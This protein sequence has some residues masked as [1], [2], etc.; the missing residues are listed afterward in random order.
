[1]WKD[2][3]ALKITG[4]HEVKSK[5]RTPN[6]IS[7]LFPE[8]DAGFLIQEVSS[9]GIPHMVCRLKRGQVNKINEWVKSGQDNEGVM[10][11]MAKWWDLC[12][13]S[14]SFKAILNVTWA[15]EHTLGKGWGHSKCGYLASNG[16]PCIICICQLSLRNK[17]DLTQMHTWEPYPS[18]LEKWVHKGPPSSWGPHSLLGNDPSGKPLINS[19]SQSE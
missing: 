3:E 5:L 17:R 13:K 9:P 18:L 8:Y 12:L 2:R 11:S 1:M 10:G 14:C 19:C 4:L 7:V 16:D 15:K 6:V